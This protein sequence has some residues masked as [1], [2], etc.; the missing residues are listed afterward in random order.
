NH[1]RRDEHLLRDIEHTHCDLGLSD[2]RHLP[3]LAPVASALPPLLVSRRFDDEDRTTAGVETTLTELGD[4]LDDA[5]A[6]VTDDDPDVRRYEATYFN[7]TGKPLAYIVSTP[8]RADDADNSLRVA[9]GNEG[10][11][12]V[13]DAFAR[14]FG[15]DVID[16]YGA[17]EG[18]VAVNREAEQRAGSLG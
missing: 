15:V 18:G 3:L 17:T 12:E 11:P 8:E 10:S 2:P 13:V 6:T 5:L 14:R 1:T 4:D 7:Y 9:F 16:A